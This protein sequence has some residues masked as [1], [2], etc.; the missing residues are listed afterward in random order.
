MIVLS[1]YG[2][3]KRRLKLLS[4]G[5]LILAGL[6]C[7][8]FTGGEDASVGALSDREAAGAETPVP[9]S[10]PGDP[11]RVLGGYDGEAAAPATPEGYW[12]EVLETVRE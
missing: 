5:L 6:F 2:A 4:A 12:T 10:Y 11:L 1:L 7:L 9:E 8:L 3:Q